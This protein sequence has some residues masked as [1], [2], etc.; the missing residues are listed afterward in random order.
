MKNYLWSIIL[1]VFH[2]E[3]GFNVNFC[4]R[5]HAQTV[6]QNV[7]ERVFACSRNIVPLIILPLSSTFILLA[8]PLAHCHESQVLGTQGRAYHHRYTTQ[9]S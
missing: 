2:L 4:V 9:Q 3:R 7:T 1:D 6:P 5:P 8:V